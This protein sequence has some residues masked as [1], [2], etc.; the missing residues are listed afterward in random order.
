MRCSVHVGNNLV[1]LFCL[2]FVLGLSEVW[3][4]ALFDG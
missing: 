3:L 4:V 2:G 1:E